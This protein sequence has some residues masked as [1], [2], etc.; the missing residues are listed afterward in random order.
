MPIFKHNDLEINYIVKGKGEPLVLIHGFGTRYQ[1]WNFQIPY[2][3]KKMKVITFDNRGVG[4]SSRPNYPY[5]MEMFVEDIKALLDYLNIQD[6]IHL[7]GISLGGMIVQNFVI[8]YPEK[9]KTLILCATSAHYDPGPL[10]KSFKLIKKL[11]LEEQVEALLP[12]T[13]SRVY[14]RKLKMDQKLFDSIKEDTLFITP[15]RDP[16]HFQDYMN[17]ANGMATHDTREFL[18]KIN[19]PTLILGANKDRIIPL[20][21]QK[22]LHEKIVNSKLEIFSGCG[23]AFIMEKPE[24][25]NKLIWNFLKENM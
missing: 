6:K 25:V 22:L 15:M 13:Y 3:E 7:C 20:P 8:K 11:S 5:T 18:D 9:V 10:F 16:T 17:Q 1:G 19:H 12:F 24:E 4:K 23:H 2:F 21:H 14:V